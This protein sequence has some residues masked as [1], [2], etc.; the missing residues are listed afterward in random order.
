MTEIVEEVFEVLCRRL[1]GP[2]ALE[3]AFWR[4]PLGPARVLLP[5]NAVPEVEELHGTVR[6]GGDSS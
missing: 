2:F 3:Y 1:W 4:G 5:R 6:I